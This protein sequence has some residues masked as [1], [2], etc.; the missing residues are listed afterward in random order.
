MN[1]KLLSVFLAILLISCI[2]GTFLAFANDNPDAVELNAQNCTV[3]LS[4]ELLAY[5]GQK[6]EPAVQVTYNNS[7][8]TKALAKDSDY[9]VSYSNNVEVG[10][11]SVT[12][13]GINGYTGE[14]GA[15]FYIVPAKVTSLKM[16]KTEMNSISISWSKVHG[17]GTYHICVHDETNNLWH[18]FYTD[19][20]KN[21]YKISGLSFSCKCAIMVQ[22]Y[23]IV[24]GKDLVGEYSDTVFASTKDAISKPEAGGYCNLTSKPVVTWKKVNEATRYSV[25]RS[26]SKNSGYKWIANVD[27]NKLSYTDKSAKVHKAYYY[28]VKA[29]RP[30]NGNLVY[31]RPSAPVWIKAKKTVLVGDSIMEAVKAYKALPG[32]SYVVKIGM[33]TYT[34]YEKNYFKVK[35]STV[36]GVEKVISMKPDRVFLM[37]GMNETAYKKNKGIIQ[38]YEYAIEDI[39]AACKGVEIVILPVSPTT[40]TSGK[41]IPK[42]KRINSF[43]SAAQKMAKRMGVKYYDFTAPYKDKNGYL[44]KAY[45]GGDGCHWNKKGTKVFINELNKYA[46]ANR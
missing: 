32:G 29:A 45:N 31:S 43:N 4:A 25:Y 1:K 5:N 12:V 6:Q 14:V 19:A 39:K 16:T 17:A 10:K 42:K 2:T 22:A 33:G 18:D 27:A 11:A 26:D 35:K 24:E 40:R 41:T 46:K 36:T 23:A 28:A 30:L 7:S 9:K 13:T 8:E 20:S 34:F 38:Y 37:F 15:N 3:K 44:K 21:T